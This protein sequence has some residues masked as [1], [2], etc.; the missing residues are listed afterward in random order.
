MERGEHAN[1]E[2]QLRKANETEI[3]FI[4]R[5]LCLFLAASAARYSFK[6]HPTFHFRG[7]SGP[8]FHAGYSL[9]SYRCEG[10]SIQ[11]Q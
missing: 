7:S 5:Y 1:K 10:R 11:S 9:S 4:H 8:P 3:W 6:F 2:V